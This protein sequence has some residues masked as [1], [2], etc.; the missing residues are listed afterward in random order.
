[1]YWP[2]ISVQKGYWGNEITRSLKIYRPQSNSMHGIGNRLWKET[3]ELSMISEAMIPIIRQNK[4][5]SGM[6]I[7]R[8]QLYGASSK[9]KSLYYWGDMAINL[10][11]FVNLWCGSSWHGGGYYTGGPMVLL[12][13]LQRTAIKISLT[14]CLSQ[15]AFDKRWLFRS[16]VFSY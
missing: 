7:Y 10:M 3:V 14:Q 4:D 5:W 6:D 2:N 11:Q 12:R 13:I 8:Y 9:S 1:M 15:H 16:P